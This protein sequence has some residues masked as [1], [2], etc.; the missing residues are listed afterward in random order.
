MGH[1]DGRGSC[2]QRH[3]HLTLIWFVRLVTPPLCSGVLLIPLWRGVT[4]TPVGDL[5]PNP[6]NISYPKFSGRL[7]KGGGRPVYP[8][9]TVADEVRDGA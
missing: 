2:K 6:K 7:V 5:D 3:P 9:V 4:R 1:A 8:G